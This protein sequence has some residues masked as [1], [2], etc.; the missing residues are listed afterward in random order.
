MSL[1][2]LRGE[3]KNFPLSPGLRFFL[4]GKNDLGLL[5]GG[6]RLELAGRGKSN[7]YY[8]SS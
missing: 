4:R 7:M 3:E 5:Q 8:R 1:V 6:G 2:R